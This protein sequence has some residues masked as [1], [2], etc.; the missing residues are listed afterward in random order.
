MYKLGAK[1][2]SLYNG[3]LDSTFYPDEMYAAST[4]EER[5]L[6]SGESFLA[7]LYPPTG[8]QLWNKNVRWQ[9]TP[10][11]SNSTDRTPVSTVIRSLCAVLCDDGYFASV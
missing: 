10:F 4:A 9:P 6:M 2:R 5:T 11:Y 7:G 3:F 1:I 8:F